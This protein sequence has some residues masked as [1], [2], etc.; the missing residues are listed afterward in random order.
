MPFRHARSQK[1]FQTLPPAWE[2]FGKRGE[3]WNERQNR[4]DS[5]HIPGTSLREEC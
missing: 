4:T 5:S 1:A 3:G 2:T